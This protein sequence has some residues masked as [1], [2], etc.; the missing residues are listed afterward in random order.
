MPGPRLF[1]L[2]DR[3]SHAVRQGL[4]RRARDELGISMVHL[5]A[6]F[7]LSHH[8]GCL[9]KELADALGVQAAAI[10]G[11]VDRMVEAG[12]AQ[13]RQCSEDGRAQR[14]HI[15]AHG[16]RVAGKAG[17][18]VNAM[19]RALTEGF[20]DDEIAIV[21]RF[22]AAAATRELTPVPASSPRPTEPTRSTRKTP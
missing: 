1:L 9:S 6:L 19:Q 14:V 8:D 3:A 5:G 18:V 16:K 2:L 13:R 4:E 11:L 12:L 7:H 15:T 10:T 17:P 20:T 22:L 21:A